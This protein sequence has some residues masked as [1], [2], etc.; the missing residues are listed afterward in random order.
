MV[1]DEGSS[2]ASATKIVDS[3]RW[4]AHMED[5]LRELEIRK[6]HPNDELLVQLVRVQLVIER[7]SLAVWFDTSIEREAAMRAPPTLYAAAM[8]KQ[9]EELETR[10]SE[11]TRQ[12]R[13]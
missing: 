2:T 10:M 4:T 9:L 3:L 6:E 11:T 7:A 5:C 13:E 1:T 12:N 8:L